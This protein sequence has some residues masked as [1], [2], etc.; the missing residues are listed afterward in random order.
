MPVYPNMIIMIL[1]YRYCCCAYVFRWWKDLNLPA[2]LPYARD[3]LMEANIS[4][5]IKYFEPCYSRARVILCKFI[6]VMTFVDDTFDS[7]GTIEELQHFTEAV[8]RFAL[9]STFYSISLF[10]SLNLFY[11]Y[12]WDADAL[13][14]LFLVIS[15]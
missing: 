2:R 10:C 14:E 9:H 5:M 1:I 6:M 13:D 15:R 8:Y 7:Y 3:R 4:A 11:F 12:M